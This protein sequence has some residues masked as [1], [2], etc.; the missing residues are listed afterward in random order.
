M[1]V[2][3]A[4]R[5]RHD[6]LVTLTQFKAFLAA[7]RTGTFAA[8]GVELEM[9]QASVSELVRR[10]EDEHG[11]A[12][13]TRT[14][15]RLALTAAGEA[16]MPFAEQSL[17]AAE[18]GRQALRSLRSLGGGVAT[19]GLL[20]NADYYLLSDLVDRFH[21]RYPG[22]RVRLVGQNSA[23]VAAAVAS[24]EL[25][26]GLVVLPVDDEGLTVTPLMRDEVL[27]ASADPQA[28]RSP[29]LTEQLG[30][31]RLVLY[32]AHFG[33]K[34]P[35]RRQLAERA[36]L[37]GLRLEPIIEVEHVETALRLV[38]RGLG[39]TIVS[40]AVRDSSACP[41]EVLTARFAEPL[42]DTIAVVRR[43]TTVLS[44][45]TQEV[46]RMATDMLLVRHAPAPGPSA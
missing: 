6:A 43:A 20:R 31:A 35:T 17:S 5:G 1:A 3:A 16:L 41:P 13:F 19:V 29:V 42:H 36:H 11:V 10:M 39:D 44:P 40:E 2:T 4:D 24:G 34:D 21:R 46:L 15:R 18:G 22:V 14:S 37:A 28:V 45:A 38:A 9:A 33:W 30:R 32:D 27:Y 8:A 12:L 26:A 23:E 7:A 25:E